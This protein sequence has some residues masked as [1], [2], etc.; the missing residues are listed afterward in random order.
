MC[1]FEE[2]GLHPES[3]RGAPEEFSPIRALSG[4]RGALS[5]GLK[6]ERQGR[7]TSFKA[8]EVI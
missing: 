1:L 5:G 7:E 4:D 2:C 8:V 3:C 6:Q